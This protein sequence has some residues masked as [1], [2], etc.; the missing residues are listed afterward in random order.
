MTP[1]DQFLMSFDT[2]LAQ[3]VLKEAVL[4]AIIPFG[5]NKFYL[6]LQQIR[7]RR[8]DEDDVLPPCY[9]NPGAS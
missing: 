2:C 1:R 8:T 5:G 6:P 9:E 4:I 3:S 7:I